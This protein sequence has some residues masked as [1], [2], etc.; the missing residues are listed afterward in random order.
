M[1]EEVEVEEGVDM[2]LDASLKSSPCGDGWIV[3]ARVVKVVGGC[4]V[5]L[6]RGGD[7]GKLNGADTAPAPVV[8]EDTVGVRDVPETAGRMEEVNCAAALLVERT[9]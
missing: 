3:C 8:D 2:I 1:E 6:R 4:C 5:A 9:L 7:A